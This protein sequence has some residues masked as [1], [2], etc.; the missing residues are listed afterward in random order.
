M[1]LLLPEDRVGIDTEGRGLG[2]FSSQGEEG[3]GE[4]SL[5][6]NSDPNN[7]PLYQIIFLEVGGGLVQGVKYGE[8]NRFYMLYG[9]DCTNAPHAKIQG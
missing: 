9:I 5:K 3:G 8:G 4:G 2:K 7:G 1:R 6:F